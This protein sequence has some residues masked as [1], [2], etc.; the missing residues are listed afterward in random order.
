MIIFNNT[1]GTNLFTTI[2][3]SIDGDKITT[4]RSLGEIKA[5]EM[6]DWLKEFFDGCFT[7]HLGES[8]PVLGSRFIELG[9]GFEVETDVDWIDGGLV[10][11]H[12]IFEIEKS[13]K[14]FNNFAKS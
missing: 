6:T 9:N 11:C 12:S 1:A 13:L 8:E 4:L 2:V 3:I 14:K 5:S 10:N 7:N